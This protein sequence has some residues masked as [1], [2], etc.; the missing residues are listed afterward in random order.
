MEYR[1][2]VM[3]NSGELDECINDLIKEDWQ[4]LGGIS[5]AVDG[6]QP[7]CFT[8]AQAMVRIRDSA[9]CDDIE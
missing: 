8:F 9:N 6:Q 5:I 7:S 4:P 2:I 3:S 1:T